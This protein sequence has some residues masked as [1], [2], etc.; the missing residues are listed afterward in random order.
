MARLTMKICIPC[1]L[2][3]RPLTPVSF[4]EKLDRRLTPNN[5]L[6]LSP[7]SGMPVTDTTKSDTYFKNRWKQVQFYADVFWKRW[8]KEYMPTL[9]PRQKWH[10][11]KQNVRPGDIVVVVDESTRRA[12]RPLGRVLNTYP[13]K[14]GLVHSALI[15]TQNAELKRPISKLCVIVSRRV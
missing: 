13:D 15:K 5:L 12:L 6:I 1:W 8:L 14:H 4:S 9:I 2:R 3:S 10:E 11:K 7:D